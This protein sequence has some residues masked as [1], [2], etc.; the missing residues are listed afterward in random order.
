MP[1]T[2]ILERLNVWLTG[3]TAILIYCCAAKIGFDTD[4]VGAFAMKLTD[5]TNELE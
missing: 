3:T 5:A 2:M 1:S 4:V